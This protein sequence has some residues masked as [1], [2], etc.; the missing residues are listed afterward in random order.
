MPARIG[1]ELAPS[2]CRIVELD[3]PLRR[4][5]HGRPKIPLA[6]DASLGTILY[7]PERRLAIV[8]GRIVGEG[9]E[10]RGAQ[11]VEIIQNAVLLLCAS[12]TLCTL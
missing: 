10:V 7:G 8:D 1:I 9:D 6:F 11:V 4:A 2:A 12:S 3:A 5:R